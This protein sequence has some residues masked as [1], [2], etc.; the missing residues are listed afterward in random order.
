MSTGLGF[1]IDAIN[2]LEQYALDHY[3]EGGH[4]V[5]E[6]Y[7]TADYM[8][9]L[10][11]TRGDLNEAKRL[12]KQDWE[13]TCARERECAWDGP[14]SPDLVGCEFDPKLIIRS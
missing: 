9:V 10:E 14:D 5:A 3:E 11:D 1:C 13:R 8:Q 12:I 2:A 7:D 4:W 6:C